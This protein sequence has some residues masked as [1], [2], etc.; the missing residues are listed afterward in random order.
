MSRNVEL[1][2]FLRARRGGVQ[3]GDVGVEVAGTR[4]VPGLRREEVAMLTAVSV[5]YYV[6]FEHWRDVS[7]SDAV[8][9]AIARV[10]HLTRRKVT[11]VHTR[12]GHADAGRCASRGDRQAE[13]E[14]AVGVALAELRHR[15]VQPVGEPMEVAEIG[16]RIAFITD[17]IGAI[18]EL[19]EP[20][21]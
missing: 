14:T 15:D 11:A 19:T 20:G 18:I 16:Q 3:P 6:R 13:R 9:D 8:L 4:R 12:A 2:D 17:N 1:R 5:D 10:L 7:P 21:T